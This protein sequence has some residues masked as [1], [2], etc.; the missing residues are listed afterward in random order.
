MARR[1][2]VEFSEDLDAA[3]FLEALEDGESF[4]FNR[5][6]HWEGYGSNEV[7]INHYNVHQIAELRS[8]TNQIWDVKRG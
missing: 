7:W 8:G 1:I 3:A 4:D 6:G 2:T 5:L